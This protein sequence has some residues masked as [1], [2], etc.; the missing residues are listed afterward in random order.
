M[1]YMVEQWT[2]ILE[3]IMFKKLKYEKI[4]INK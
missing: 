3:L 2:L 1:E 4:G